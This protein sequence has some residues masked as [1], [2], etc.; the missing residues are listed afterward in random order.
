[1]RRIGRRSAIVRQQ[2][3]A[4]R[5]VCRIARGG[6]GGRRTGFPD[7]CFELPV[8]GRGGFGRSPALPLAG[9]LC[10]RFADA[11]HDKTL[12]PHSGRKP[13]H[14]TVLRCL[15]SETRPERPIICWLNRWFLRTNV[16]SFY[17]SVKNISKKIIIQPFSD[18]FFPDLFRI[19]PSF[20]L[21][22]YLRNE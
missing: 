9:A 20:F 19:I 10:M 1:M 7:E 14:A 13:R 21:Y 16:T 17:L 4:R 8:A 22:T 12:E 3:S 11:V 2:P 6:N 15:Q 5:L 18:T